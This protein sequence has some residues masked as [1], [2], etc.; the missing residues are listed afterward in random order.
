M[1]KKT[2][3]APAS[4]A[5][6]KTAP[7]AAATEA[8]AAPKRTTRTAAKDEHHPPLADRV[9][10]GRMNWMLFFAGLG[11]MVLGYILMSVE[12]AEYGF[13]ALGLTVGPIMLA[14]AFVVEF[15]AIMYRPKAGNAGTGSN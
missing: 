6:P 3:S 9:I 12:S 5:T 2:E 8:T 1:A 4:A 7:A 14:L 11:L 13:G 10:W 15:F